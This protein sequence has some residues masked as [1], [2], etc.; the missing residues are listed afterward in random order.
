MDNVKT[1]YGKLFGK[2]EKMHEIEGVS[3]SESKL[4]ES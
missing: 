1:K 3:E 4:L 2:I